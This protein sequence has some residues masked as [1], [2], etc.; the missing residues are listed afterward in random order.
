MEA[1]EKRLASDQWL[2]KTEGREAAIAF[3]GAQSELTN[4]Y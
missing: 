1:G 2:V 4:T 3:R